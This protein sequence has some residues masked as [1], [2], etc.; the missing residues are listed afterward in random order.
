MDRHGILCEKGFR[1]NPPARS[2]VVGRRAYRVG[3]RSPR[4][5]V[6][7]R[8]H[9]VS[10]AGRSE[11]A[12]WRR[13]ET[14]GWGGG[15]GPPCAGITQ[16]KFERCCLSTSRCGTARRAPVAR[17]W[18]GESG[19]EPSNGG[20]ISEI[21]KR[22]LKKQVMMTGQHRPWREKMDQIEVALIHLQPVYM[23]LRAGF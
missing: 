6:G 19:R 23:G 7:G 14:G 4:R 12:G 9:L 10:A 5:H 16:I 22:E 3:E 1:A 15:G 21:K 17:A 2:G 20:R 18:R 13:M 8:D 11:T